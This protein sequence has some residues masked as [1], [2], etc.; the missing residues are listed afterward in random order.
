M[1]ILNHHPC[2]ARAE[3]SAV[4]GFACTVEPAMPRRAGGN[5][6]VPAGMQESRGED[7]GQPTPKPPRVS[8]VERVGAIARWEC[9]PM[10]H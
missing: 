10:A 9:V 5:L 2:A 3:A 1:L 6:V 8:A 7:G 4:F